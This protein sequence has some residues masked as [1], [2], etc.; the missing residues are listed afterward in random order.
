MLCLWV[1]APLHG[2]CCL[3]VG[4][5]KASS[6]VT[7]QC[8]HPLS[9]HSVICLA[10]SPLQEHFPSACKMIT[11][12]LLDFPLL[13]SVSSLFLPSSHLLS[14]SLS[15]PLLP[16]SPTT[17]YNLNSPGPPPSSCFSSVAPFLLKMDAAPLGVVSREERKEE[18]LTVKSSSVFTLM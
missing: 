1:L 17:T 4:L 12:W 10:P 2:P 16:G 13:F 14:F 7:D 15:R 11:G 5:M 3:P 18:A 9:S 8:C 6:S